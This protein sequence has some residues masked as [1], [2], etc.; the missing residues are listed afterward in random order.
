MKQIIVSMIIL[1]TLTYARVV[2][3]KKLQWLDPYGREPTGYKQWHN[4][5]VDKSEITKIGNVYLKTSGRQNVVNVIVN[6]SIYSDIINELNIFTQDLINAGYSIQLDTISGMSAFVLRNHLAGITDLV[7]AIFI[8]EVP[9]AW[10]ETNG[11]GDWEE[12]PH[13]LYFCDLNGTYIDADGDGIY[14][15][16]TGNLAPEI[17]VGRIYARNLNWDNEIR[18]L[19]NYFRK[20]HLYRVDSLS[21]PQRGLS[22][23][24]DDWSYWTTCYLDYIYSNV[25]VVNDQYQTTAANYRNHL[26]QGYEWIHICA[27][28]SPWGHTFKYPTSQYRGTVFNYEIFTL[29][30][31]A[32]FYN[33]FACSGTRFVEENHSAGWYIFNDPYG[34][35]VVGSTKTGSMLYFEDFYY[36]IG[37]QNMCIGDAFKHWFTLWGENDWDWFYGM[38]ILGD[39]TLKPKG[40]I[41][42]YCNKEIYPVS[43]ISTDWEDPEIVAPNPESD[44]FPQIVVNNDG[45]VWVVWQSGRSYTNGRSDIY[46]AYRSAGGWSGAMNIGPHI[47]WDYCPVIGIDNANRPVAVWAGYN[48]GQ[49]DLYYSVYTGAWSSR[50]PVHTSD[51]GYDIKP[52]MVKDNTGRLWLAWESRRNVHLDIYAAYFDGSSWTS[53][54]RVTTNSSDETTPV[55]AIDS[56]GRLWIFYC[57]RYDDKSEIW[58]SYYTGSQWFTTGPI[59][60]SQSNAYHPACAVD[61]SGIIWVVWQS[62]DYGNPDIYASY[63]NGSSWSLPI[64]ITT[65]QGSDLFPALTTDTTG[66]IWLVYQ[67]KADGDWNIYYANCVDSTWSTPQ[68]VADLLGADINPQITCSKSNELWLCWQ[69]YS[70]GNWEIMATHRPGYGISESKSRSTQPA[71]NVSPSIFNNS[72]TIITKRACQEINIYD[73]KGA[74]LETIISDKNKCAVWT[75]QGLPNGIYFIILRDKDAVTTKKVLLMR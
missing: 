26:A 62:S 31:H 39:P 41:Q 4:L 9:V 57:Q 58:G 12:F 65:S 16:H 20:N 38:N 49:Y 72:L 63:Y 53:A 68:I 13:D 43:Q 21:L 55:M 19:K 15:N 8:G 44:G 6:A 27:H 17:W 73:I 23:V 25:V 59:S 36:P 51:P 52:A 56:L 75:P 66:T 48:N 2:G 11:F 70:S 54:Q 22:F 64:Q 61:E 32:L 29:E 67:S 28:S 24:D 37:Q 7:G 35:L 42:C 45:T 71:F 33:L 60:G 50:Q 3:I 46:G 40:Q 30:P 18:L 34:L 14:D 47:Y 5:Y 69:S 1:T 10:F 74:L